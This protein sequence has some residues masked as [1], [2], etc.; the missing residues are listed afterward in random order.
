[1]A[2][3]DRGKP[4]KGYL[5]IGADGRVEF[6]A[7]VARTYGLQPGCE[8]YAQAVENGLALR[9]PLGTLER[10]YVE[11]TNTCNLGCRTCI[12]HVW[13]E[14]LGTMSELT[15]EKVLEGVRGA[16]P[17]PSMFFGGFGEP[18][19][20]PDIL[21]MVRAAHET[22]A[23]TEL[24][25]NGVLLSETASVGLIEAGLDFLW[26]SIDGATPASYLDVRLGNELPRIIGNLQELRRQRYLRGSSHPQLGIA[27]VAMKRNLKEWPEVVSLGRRL[28]ARRFNVS[29]VLPH[30]PE[31]L[32]EVLYTR[33]MWENGWGAGSLSLPRMDASPELMEAWSRVAY[34]SDWSAV[35]Q[36]PFGGSKDSCPFVERG[37]T[38]VRWDGLVSPCLPLL[39]AHDSYLGDTHRRNQ[40]YFVGSLEER[41]LRSIWQDPV[42]S[43]LRKR[44][45]EFDFSPCTSC[46]SCE[47]AEANVEDCFGSVPPVCG[48]CLWAQGFIRCP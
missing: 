33:S 14:P 3:R 5:S 43:S 7:E 38:S 1:M 29:N 13:N 18:L 8:V 23:C 15:Y 22:G 45:Q 20:H 9:R 39:H 40:A 46:N 11:P 30:T 17:R 25:T 41:S 35:L 36:T 16:E 31:M 32:A 37:S 44:L 42:Y 48:G 21:A 34:H 6:P 10:V 19:G 12:R 27:F 4:W 47:M 28:G 24:I 26:V 2:G